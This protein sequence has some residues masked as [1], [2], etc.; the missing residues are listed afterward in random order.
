[1]SGAVEVRSDEGLSMMK[2]SSSLRGL[3]LN[4]KLVY[5]DSTETYELD[6]EIAEDMFKYLSV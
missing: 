5:S 6:P 3:V 2:H 1:M 4:N